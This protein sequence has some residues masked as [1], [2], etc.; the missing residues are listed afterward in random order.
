MS[1]LRE[2]IAGVI[3][4]AGTPQFATL[5]GIALAV[6]AAVLYARHR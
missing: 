6:V 4:I 2:L 1:G 5:A 3:G